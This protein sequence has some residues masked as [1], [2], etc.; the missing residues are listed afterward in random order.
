MRE[1]DYADTGG[2][3][4][5][6]CTYQREC[7]FGEVVDGEMRLNEAGQC[8]E[9]W[10]QSIPEHFQNTRVDS[11]VIMPNHFHGVIMLVGAGSP[12]PVFQ[13]NE[14]GDPENQ[15]GDPE[16]QGGETPPT[17]SDVG[18]GCRIFQI[19][20]TRHINELRDNPGVPC[21]SATITNTSSAMPTT[22]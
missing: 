1:Y 6:I 9:K 22:C 8:V 18:T 10:W 15:G 7:Q 13:A 14:G 12:R 2:Y 3:F 11:F 21:G 19:P 17:V 4:V 16:N 20:S 5:T